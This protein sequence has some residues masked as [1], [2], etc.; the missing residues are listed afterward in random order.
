MMPS[1]FANVSPIGLGLCGLR[2]ANT[3]TFPPSKRGGLT[4]ALMAL[5]VFLWNKKMT[6]KCT[7]QIMLQ[8]LDYKQTAAHLLQWQKRCKET[9]HPKRCPNFLHFQSRV[10]CCPITRKERVDVHDNKQEQRKINTFL[11]GAPKGRIFPNTTEVSQMVL[12]MLK[13][14]FWFIWSCPK[15]FLSVRMC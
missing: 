2:D 8:R 1:S 7:K 3:P 12:S 14:P 10:F 4:F 15:N 9:N 13:K 11:S 5:L 6:L